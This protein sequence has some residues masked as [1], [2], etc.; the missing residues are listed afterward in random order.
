MSKFLFTATAV[1]A[2][3]AAS[4]QQGP[5]LTDKDYARAESFLSYNTEPLID[6]A[7]VRPN[8]LPGD[9]FW[10]RDLDAHGSEFILVDPA[11]KSIS[12]VFDQGKLAAALS[13]ATGNHY[14]GLMLPFESFAYSA[15]GK[16]VIFRA[17][18]KQWKCDL[19]SYQCVP[20]TEKMDGGMEGVGS[21][22]RFRGA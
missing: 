3:L 14:E 2:V 10:F 12:G 13:T 22:R 8:W 9:K 7:V 11:K 1:L 17:D 15:D 5:V 6:H 18:G 20:D 16:S 4:A 21:G 19:K